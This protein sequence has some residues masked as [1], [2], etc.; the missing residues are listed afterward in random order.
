[1]N[2]NN[3]QLADF[4]KVMHR[5]RHERV[6]PPH[7]TN[8]VQADQLKLIDGKWQT[9]RS[10]AR[11]SNMGS[12]TARSGQVIKTYWWVPAGFAVLVLLRSIMGG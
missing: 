12:L 8:Y 2:I 10:A 6:Y 9:I 7:S 4:I 5:E 11:K 1:V 3:P